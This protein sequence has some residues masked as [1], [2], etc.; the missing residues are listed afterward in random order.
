MKKTAGELMETIPVEERFEGSELRV[1]AWCP[2][3]QK[4]FFATAP[5][6]IA[7]MRGVVVNTAITHVRC[8]HP[9]D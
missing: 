1:V 7:E 3:C 6:T 9:E 4:Q 8:F 5:G 2:V